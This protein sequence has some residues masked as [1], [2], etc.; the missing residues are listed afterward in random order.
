MKR[1]LRSNQ[2]GPQHSS[3]RHPNDYT[4]NDI[5]SPPRSFL[6][7]LQ[8]D[9]GG[10]VDSDSSSP[11]FT[12][13]VALD[14]QPQQHDLDENRQRRYG[15][16]NGNDYT[17]ESRHALHDYG[18][19]EEEGYHTGGL[20]LPLYNTA[21]GGTPGQP[22]LSTAYGQEAVQ[23]RRAGV[24]GS[25]SAPMTE[26][27]TALLYTSDRQDAN[28]YENEDDDGGQGKQWGSK[29]FGPGMGMGG[30][31]GLP[32]QR[33]KPV[34]W[35]QHLVYHE[36]IVWTVVYTLLA[37]FTRYYKIGIANYVVWDEAH[38]GKFGSHYIN[39]DFYF[40][41]HPPLGKMLVGLAGLLSGYGG[42]F[43]FKSGATYPPEVPYTAMRVMLATFGAAM[44]PI[45]W[46]TAG[47]FGWSR[48]T[49]HW[50]TLCVLCDVAWIT[51]SRFILL[52]SMLLFFTFTTVLGMVKFHNQRHE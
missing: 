20:S 2:T 24:P 38:F 15:A 27:E 29:G 46:W 37:M 51:I 36:E 45:A 14:Q 22:D 11:Y 1:S 39:Q 31:R 35:Q 6:P 9:S 23:R 12:H 26:E 42:G 17:Y 3:H 44:V 40:D 19:D 34:T 8:G 43:D 33:P 7:S 25:G 28:R 4:D 32:P 50:V 21:M 41:V 30:R 49:R 48:K 13:S 18:V 10:R 16:Y 47:E 5:P 52:D